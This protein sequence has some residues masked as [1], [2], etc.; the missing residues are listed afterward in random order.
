LIE[1]VLA[2][3][4]TKGFARCATDLLLE[5]CAIDTTPRG[6][7]SEMG[8]AEGAVFDVDEP[9]TGWTVSCDARLFATEHPGMPV[10]T[11]G[12]GHVGRAHSDQEQLSIA[13]LVQA[14]QFLATY[15]ILG[16]DA[17]EQR[18]A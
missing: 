15:L 16:P 10:L 2:R 5:L 4:R 7:V 6:D 12:P 3:T 14:V 8:R 13:E 18:P 1:R 17:T 11:V 9:V